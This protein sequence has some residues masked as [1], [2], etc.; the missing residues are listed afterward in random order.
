MSHKQAS[1]YL[2]QFFQF[3]LCLFKCVLSAHNTLL[4]G[5]ITISVRPLDLSALMN[6]CAVHTFQEYKR[7]LAKVTQV[8]KELR[9]RL[10]GLPGGLYNSSN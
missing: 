10:N 8:R 4:L 7:K 2:I 9:S 1:I 6:F 5:Q 3:R